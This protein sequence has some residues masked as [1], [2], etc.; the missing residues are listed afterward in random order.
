MKF[1]WLNF[2]IFISQAFLTVVNM[3][4]VSLKSVFGGGSVYNAGCHN[5]APGSCSV[6]DEKTVDLPA[7]G[8]S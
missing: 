2:L 7:K 5:D 1:C 8:K 4:L 3:S 6:E